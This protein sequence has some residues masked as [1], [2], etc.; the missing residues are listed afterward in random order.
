MSE[1]FGRL[2]WLAAARGKLRDARRLVAGVGAEG[3]PEAVPL[4][5]QVLG[6][7]LLQV[8]AGRRAAFAGWPFVC[9]DEH[10]WAVATQRRLLLLGGVVIDWAEGA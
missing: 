7:V 9:F 4:V 8:G 5:R 6:K 10:S 1:V 2:R 3:V